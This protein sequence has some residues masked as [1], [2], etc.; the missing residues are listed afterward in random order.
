[1]KQV[2]VLICG[3]GPVGLVA[4]LR[5]A[6]AGIEA[7]SG[8]EFLDLQNCRALLQIDCKLKFKRL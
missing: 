8:L 3:A 7:G 1:M 6:L 5:L 4:G 2:A